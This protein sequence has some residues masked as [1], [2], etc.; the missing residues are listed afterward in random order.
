MWAAGAP[1][2]GTAVAA[3]GAQWRGS[4]LSAPASRCPLP[5]ARRPPPPRTAP[6]A[7]GSGVT[8][9]LAGRTHSHPPAA[10]RG[11]AA[12]SACWGNNW[13]SSD[14]H[15]CQLQRDALGAGAAARSAL[16][17]PPRSAGFRARNPRGFPCA[18]SRAWGTLCPGLA[19]GY[20]FT[21]AWEGG[22]SFLPASTKAGSGGL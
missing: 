16:P 4:V 19:T 8:G 10:R 21:Q 3:R 15:R 17:E 13:R 2:K 9:R 20:M 18:P 14:W 5:A 7:Q 6:R 12:P 1:E 22:V 11:W